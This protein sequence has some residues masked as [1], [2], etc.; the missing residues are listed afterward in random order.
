MSPGNHSK[1][2]FIFFLWCQIVILS[3]PLH[4][5]QKALEN[6]KGTLREKIEHL[7]VLAQ[8]H[9]QAGE[10]NLAETILDSIISLKPDYETYLQLGR[11]NSRKK[12][13]LLYAEASYKN[14]I[15]VWNKGKRAV[16][17]YE[18][19]MLYKDGPFFKNKAIDMFDHAILCDKTMKDAY[20]QRA[21]LTMIYYS[22]GAGLRELEKLLYLDPWYKNSYN[23][24]LKIGLAFHKFGRMRK[25]FKK[26][27]VK[28]PD[29]LRFQLAYIDALYRDRKYAR[30][31]RVV[32][33]FKEEHPVQWLSRQNFEEARI[34]LA[35]NQ[36]TLGTERYR[37]AV[38]TIADESDAD[39]LFSDIIYL[40]SDA[41]Y[42]QYFASSLPE[43]K[44]FF[45]Q[46]WQKRDPTLT[47]PFNERIPEH[48]KRLCYARRYNRR[49]PVKEF[50][51]FFLNDFS[52]PVEREAFIALD[53][54]SS[55]KGSKFQKDVDDMGVIYIRHG[56]PD[57]EIP[58]D[59]LYAGEKSR[60]IWQPIWRY[61]SKY[62]RPEM[63]FRFYLPSSQD[64][65][66]SIEEG[67]CLLPV[68]I[69]AIRYATATSTCNYEPEFGR[70]DLA[71]RYFS[72][73][74]RTNQ[75]NVYLYYNLPPDAQPDSALSRPFS[76]KEE[77]VLFDSNWQA[78]K[79]YEWKKKAGLL[80][81]SAQGKS[82]KIF[83]TLSPGIYHAG[84]RVVNNQTLKEG[85]LRLKIK[86]PSYHQKGL[87]SSDIVLGKQ[88]DNQKIFTSGKLKFSAASF[89]V[90]KI[91][92]KF[93]KNELLFI[94][95]EVYNLTLNA[96]AQSDFSV[97]INVKQIKSHG[98]GIVTF[99][100]NPRSLFT[101]HILPEMTIS[102]HFSTENRDGF[103]YRA[104]QLPDYP[105]GLYRLTVT[106]K[107]N[108]TNKNCLMRNNFEILK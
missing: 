93:K 34:R 1:I 108:L 71:S 48:Y 96:D 32:L 104:I 62:G 39:R 35:L 79:R 84:L 9:L 44:E 100:K 92:R 88:E 18:L 30:A 65:G 6:D 74:G 3:H 46:F 33:A 67:W 21:L 89:I 38:N 12:D 57:E 54:F 45:R 4:S 98:L 106:V 80:G 23:L 59:D 78:V 105:A 73:K 63:S 58:Y 85:L 2:L 55:T 103:L 5:A 28:Y 76:L 82:E 7:H 53:E 86:V 24:Y 61:Y 25:A 14:A 95:F 83:Q 20:Y 43:K 29:N 49:Y 68:D 90:P 27:T 64:S 16:A 66:R 26:L 15:K 107:D 22:Y 13:K 75:E 41:E 70:F 50:L 60:G 52:R 72:F 17:Y 97:T 51:S 69:Q 8:K 77:F 47:T 56:D 101:K 31:L 94:Y 40:V 11:I 99:L 87:K 10:N 37:Q 19:G 102:D 36:D 81:F 91:S 42:E